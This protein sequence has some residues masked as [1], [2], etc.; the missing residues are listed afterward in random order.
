MIPSGKGSRLLPEG[1][2]FHRTI[3]GV[4]REYVE[5]FTK[6]DKSLIQYAEDY[7][8]FFLNTLHVY[9]RVT[10]NL[11]QLYCE[12]HEE[13][14][15]PVHFEIPC[16]MLEEDIQPAIGKIVPEA[17]WSRYIQA[18]P[19]EQ[20]HRFEEWLSGS[21]WKGRDSEGREVV[22]DIFKEQ[23]VCRDPVKLATNQILDLKEFIDITFFMPG[24]GSGALK[25]NLKNGPPY[26][27][28]YSARVKV[29]DHK[30]PFGAN[31]F[32]AFI[33]EPHEP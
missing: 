18:L 29:K 17:G 26:R 5:A 15:D 24:N 30:D 33:E 2:T 19:K 10:V 31:L 13:T 8:F 7:R 3:S 28:C 1:T 4:D 21:K 32:K 6:E 25:L 12:E 23:V 11:F 22:Y 16:Q 14:L 9:L 20:Y 27:C